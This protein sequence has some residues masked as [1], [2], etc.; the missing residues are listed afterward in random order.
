MNVLFMSIGI[1]DDLS[2]SSVHI[3]ILKRF[4]Q[5][6]NVYLVCKNEKKE[7]QFSVEFGIHI[8][9]VRTDSLKMVGLIKKGI[10]TL[11]VESE[12]KN[13]IKNYFS[14]V[15]FDLVL[16]TTPPI[17]FASAVAFIK[18]RDNALTYLMLKDIFPQNAVDLGMMSKTGIQ[19]LIYNYFRKKEK[20]LY[21]FSDFIGCM[22]PANCVYILRHNPEISPARVEVCPNITVIEDMSID[23]NARVSIRNRY[24]I[25]LDKKVF[26]YGGNL[27]K[28]QGI[29]FLIECLKRQ[30]FNDVFFVVIGSGTEYPL[31][32]SFVKNE[33]PD[34]VMLLRSLP[35]TDYETL[36]A[37]CDVGMIFLDYRFTIPNFPSRMLSYMKSK[38][39]ILA[40][41]DP[42]TDIGKIIVKGGFGWWCESNDVNGFI[43][44]VQEITELDA[45]DF[46]KMKDIEFGYLK[47]NYNPDVAYNTIIS[48]CVETSRFI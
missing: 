13:A 31:L 11:K 15:K 6:H 41:T 20:E 33:A 21:K 1:F 35:K 23:T 10:A 38:I 19:G 40:A 46:L 36:V 48:K 14:D 47:D 42:N 27:G 34:N 8:L 16:Y 43:S 5:D 39:P 2:G 26:I 45:Q 12:F 4:A 25:P 30:T 32:E 24:N 7:T 17:T 29:P 9:R 18:K 37:A 22:S 3:D 44:K 28:P